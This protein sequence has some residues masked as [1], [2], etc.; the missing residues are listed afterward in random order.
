MPSDLV[1]VTGAT[2]FIGSHVARAL[3]AEGY[4]VRAL[5]RRPGAKVEGAQTVEGDLREPGKL[6]HNLRDCRYLVH[7]AA[8]YSFAP[9]D[10]QLMSEVNV[11]GTEGLLEA[12]RVAGVERAVVTSSG[13]TVG[14]ASN[15]TPAT[16]SGWSLSAHRSAYHHSK[17]EQERAAL[18]ARVPT[19]LVLPTSPVGPGDWKPTP[20]GRLVLDFA[21]GR[22]PA[23]PSGAGGINLV[24]VEDVARAHV[25]ALRLG[26]ARERYLVGGENLTFDEVWDLL[27]AATGRPAPRLRLPFAVALAAGFVDELR[28]RVSASAV[29]AVPLEGVRM[30]RERMYVDSSKASKELGYQAGSVR[31]ALGRA[32]A[33][34]RANGY[35]N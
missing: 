15:G 2:G 19:V 20:T 30:S 3:V 9:R 22:I 8:L 1:F 23:R 35:L 27:A 26:T 32:V 13:S 18:A 34:Y 10:R 6:A 12:A 17:L 31:D 11:A 21:R 16:E 33:W 4:R 7:C 5:V 24:A 14:P 25:A 29:P 28:C